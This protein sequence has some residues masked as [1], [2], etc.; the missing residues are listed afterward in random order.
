[1]SSF[2]RQPISARIERRNQDPRS[3]RFFVFAIFC[4]LFF[5]TYL[6]SSVGSIVVPVGKYTI[7][8]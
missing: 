7:E 8:K 5:V 6:V 4:I 1:M 3:L 2:F